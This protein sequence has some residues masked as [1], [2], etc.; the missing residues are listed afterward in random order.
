[1]QRA[2][3]GARAARDPLFA[4][5]LELTT[6]RAPPSY[7]KPIARAA[8]PEAARLA[9][10]PNGFGDGTVSLSRGAPAVADGA[11][12]RPAN[13]CWDLLSCALSPKPHS[14][15]SGEAI[16]RHLNRQPE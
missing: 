1:M 12:S 11:L 6:S 13:A 2:H 16:P 9:E 4:W 10:P 15:P 7:N 5:D 8:A 3:Q 14:A